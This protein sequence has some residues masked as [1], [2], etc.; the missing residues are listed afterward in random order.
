MQGLHNA[1]A[2]PFYHSLWHL[3][4]HILVFQ[5]PSFGWGWGWAWCLR[6]IYKI[7]RHQYW[8][9]CYIPFCCGKTVSPFTFKWA[10]VILLSIII[11]YS[12]SWWIFCLK[13]DLWQS[14]PETNRFLGLQ[15]NI[16]GGLIG[17]VKSKPL[18]PGRI[19]S[20]DILVIVMII[21]V[22]HKKLIWPPVRAISKLKHHLLDLT[23]WT[24]VSRAT[25]AIDRWRH[26]CVHLSF[27]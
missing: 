9:F 18:G 11:I 24:T 7:D 10:S 16:R 20:I 5:E 6:I 15:N 2:I 12:T 22:F 3:S 25:T 14:V 1:H 23:L 8:F 26:I 17:Y 21:A 19:I 27:Q 4:P 13:G